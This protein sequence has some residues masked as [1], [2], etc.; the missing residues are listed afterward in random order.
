MKLFVSDI[1]DVRRSMPADK[2]FIGDE[3][4]VEAA[5]T[6]YRLDI[7]YYKAG[8]VV[9][10][11]V[12]GEA[13]VRTVCSRCAE[14]IAVTFDVDEEFF[15][16]PDDQKESVDYVYIGDIVEIDEFIHEALVLDMPQYVLCSEQCKG[17]CPVCGVDLN[18]TQCQ[19]ELREYNTIKA[20][21]NYGGS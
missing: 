20:G 1:S 11:R 4:A 10:L 6:D 15:L 12:F 13:D 16:F 8:D 21:G 14:P 18:T 3:I 7:E 19:C 17:R 5:L 9:S 2:L